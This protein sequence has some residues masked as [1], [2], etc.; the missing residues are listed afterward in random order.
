MKK[1]S[2]Q[3]DSGRALR[4]AALRRVS[5][6]K[7]EREGESLKTQ[8]NDLAHDIDELEGIFFQWYGGQEHAVE[9]FEKQEIER[10]LRDAALGLFDAVIVHHADRW[11][12]QNEQSQT[13]LRILKQHGIR[14]FIR[15]DEQDLFDENDRLYLGMSAVI[16]EY[17]ALRQA[18]SSLLNRINRARRGEPTCGKLPFGR[19]YDAQAK[20]WK[21]D[22]NKAATIREVA[23]RYL[24][25]EALPTL[26]R[27]FGMNHS[28]LHKILTKRAGTEWV[29]TFSSQR[30]N[31][32]EEVTIQIPELLSAETIKAI[33]ERAEANRT[34]A[35]GARTNGTPY[36]L[37]RVICC[38]HCGYGMFG[39]LNHGVTRYY[40]HVH[41]ERD[42]EC[43]RPKSWVRADELEK[44][45]MEDLFECFGNPAAV[46]SAVEEAI[47]NLERIKQTEKRLEE[48]EGSLSKVKTGR[49][50]VLGLVSRLL[51]TD[52]QAEDQL[53]AL[54][55]DEARLGAERLQLIEYVSNRP[56]PHAIE[57]V[58]Q[59]LSS[60]FR[61]A[62]YP[63]KAAIR[64]VSKI[65]L[66]NS[67][68]EEMS[69]RDKRALLEA[70]F[71]GKTPEGRRMGVHIS[72]DES[73]NW[74]YKIEGRLLDP[75]TQLPTS[76][77]HL[78]SAAVKS[79]L[80]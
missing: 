41:A 15:T 19:I 22:D 65:R 58:A 75:V 50:K 80:C 16:G 73:G 47:P 14:F 54:A 49:A 20:S 8:S 7:Q 26:A 31:I 68:I 18:K 36:L 48:V 5:T 63:T 9:G 30:L 6:E 70:V 37:G 55:A 79:A 69:W 66:A 61:C 72:W 57:E 42:R 23:R 25:G 33:R 10:L 56:T 59:K 78:A 13:G 11:S 35:H 51:V 71:S 74:R 46:R 39:Q 67:Q 12:R 44:M 76:R 43:P 64:M 24:A 62:T 2:T 34:W 32:H 29:Q 38:A 60:R 17:H 4:F 53:A 27:E 52:Q 40:R 77:A 21:L 3:Q 45:V 1:T 28:N